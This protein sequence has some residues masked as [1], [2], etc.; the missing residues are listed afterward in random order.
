MY[1]GAMTPLGLC[2][3]SRFTNG[4]YVLRPL[5]ASYEHPCAYSALVVVDADARIKFSYWD[6]IVG[7]EAKEML[8]ESGGTHLREW[9]RARVTGIIGDSSAREF[10]SQVVLREGGKTIRLLQLASSDGPL[11]GLVVEGDRDDGA[12]ARAAARYLLTRRQ[13]EV[14]VL[15]LGGA[16]ASDIARSLVISEYTAQGYVK[17]LLAKT[18]SRNRAA[19]VAKVLNWKQPRPAQPRNARAA[20]DA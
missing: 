16:S 4:M 3:H 13:T 5:D 8:C 18:D 9:L 6:G 15:V 10:N 19:M 1:L 14:L 7:H 20:S 2:S 11:F 17:G 12:I